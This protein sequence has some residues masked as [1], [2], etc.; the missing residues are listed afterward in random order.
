MNDAARVAD[1]DR[2][3][4]GYDHRYSFLRYDGVR[5]TLMG[6]LGTDGPRVLEVGCGT[7]HWLRAMAGRP[8]LLAGID[9]SAGMLAKAKAHDAGARIVRARAEDL[10]W[11]D[12]AFDRL[13]CVNAL[14]HFSDRL[15]FFAEA[16]RVLRPGGALLTIGK[17]PHAERDDW[18][19]YDYF[20]E[21][22]GIDRARFAPVRI[23]RGELARAGFDWAESSEADR[24]EAVQPASDALV[25]GTVTP[26]FTSQ[27]TV[28]TSEE[29]DRGVARL[30]AANDAAGGGLQLITDFRLYAVVGRV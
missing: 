27:L 8:S 23:L 13:F 29:F 22:V 3:A 19:V 30:R 2:V 24:L 12:A 11:A 1:Y 17:D 28:L 7:G 9:F 14:H 6:F 26:A 10:P 20:P 5:E 25:D 21:T 4:D 18:W 16:R 15:R